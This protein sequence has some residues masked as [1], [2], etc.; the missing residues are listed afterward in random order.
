[1]VAAF[2]IPQETRRSRFVRDHL[3]SLVSRRAYT[4]WV[5][6]SPGFRKELEALLAD[7]TFDIVH[8]DSLDLVAYL[9]TVAGRRVVLAH[10]NVES[11]LM[12]R[13]AA[14]ERGLRRL[15]LLEQA[16]LLKREERR[17]T[18]LVDANVVVSPD[19]GATLQKIAPAAKIVVV[20]NGVDTRAFQPM[21]QAPSRE[22]VFIGGYTWFPNR[23]GM[24]FFAGEVLPLIRATEPD[25]RVTWIGRAPQHVRDEYAD[26][27][28]RLTGY[29]DDIRPH[30][31]RGACV[32]VPLRVGG[33]TRLKI[34][35]AWAMGKAVV[36][37]SAGCEGLAVRQG[38]NMLVADDP[39][40]FAAAVLRVLN[41]GV[42][43]ARLGSEGRATVE[44]HYDWDVIGR[45]M[46]RAY[47]VISRQ[48]GAE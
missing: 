47:S 46:L 31:A 22:I 8:V 12:A 25:L 29:V 39:P 33:G 7:R 4:R 45:A 24:E 38:E 37:T 18:P 14:S 32:V 40:A 17:W 41:D 19:D 43:R 6:E 1:M 16:R 27:G 20:P 35:D 11:Q 34:L 48:S 5:Y 15:Y 42:L 28:I 44:T 10:H 23:D 2:E 13:R 9:P 30:V 21:D 3:F 36:S 26:L